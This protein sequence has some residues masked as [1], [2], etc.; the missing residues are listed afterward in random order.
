MWCGKKKPFCK[1]Q[2]IDR[3]T[4]KSLGFQIHED[5][6][7]TAAFILLRSDCPSV[8][9]IWVVV[10]LKHFVGFTLLVEGEDPGIATKQIDIFQEATIQDIQ[11]LASV[12]GV[13]L[14]LASS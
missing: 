10:H 1:T 12:F 14:Q 8:A 7:E 6:N 9:R 11:N 13:S 5:D 2:R 3:K 4:L